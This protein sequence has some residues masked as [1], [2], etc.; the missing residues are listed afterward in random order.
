MR[1]QWARRSRR[2]EQLAP[3]AGQQHS[4]AQ[5]F[6]HHAPNKQ[7][8]AKRASCSRGK[9]TCSPQA[10]G[11]THASSAEGQSNCRA[12]PSTVCA[13]SCCAMS[14]GSP[15]RTPP[16]A[17]ASIMTNTYA[18]PLPLSP[19]TA[20]SSFSSTLRAGNNEQEGLRG[21]GG[22]VHV[23]RVLQMNLG[24]FAHA[25]VFLGSTSCVGRS[26]RPRLPGRQGCSERLPAQMNQQQA[27][28][29]CA[30][31]LCTLCMLCTLPHR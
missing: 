24:L 29:M 5:S 22:Q 17:S 20:L 7:A 28:S 21:G 2:R 12:H 30:T 27:I 13:A 18:G 1:S 4:A 10:H 3:G 11:P 26:T 15:A 9:P 14:R 6:R 25:R 8:P 19:V 16:S 31:L 23:W